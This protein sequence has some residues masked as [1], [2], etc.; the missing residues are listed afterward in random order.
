MCNWRLHSTLECPFNT[1]H[2]CQV[3]NKQVS[4]EQQTHVACYFGILLRTSRCQS[5]SSAS[6]ITWQ[7]YSNAPGGCFD[8]SFDAFPLHTSNWSQWM[9]TAF[10]KIIQSPKRSQ[11]RQ[12]TGNDL[13]LD[14][15]GLGEDCQCT[16]DRR[17]RS[18][19]EAHSPQ[20]ISLACHRNGF[21]HPFQVFHYF[22]VLRLKCP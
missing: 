14:W 2:T 17:S 7:G 12:L 10:D 4:V 9:Y 11:G 3:Q 22:V 19:F 5:Y 13:V 20:S 16:H 18:A 1:F 6:Q 15:I 8:A 21:A